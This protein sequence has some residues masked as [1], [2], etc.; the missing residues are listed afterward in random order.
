[1]PI[2][3]LGA[4][5]ILA[6]ISPAWAVEPGQ[7]VIEQR[8]I[9]LPTGA[10]ANLD[11]LSATL[12]QGLDSDSAKAWAIYRWL[13]ENIRYD[14][15]GLK[16]GDYGDLSPEGV[17][18]SRKAV[19]SGYS[20]LFK[21]LG[22]RAGL[23]VMVIKGYSRGGSYRAGEW[24]AQT[25]HAWNAVKV[26]GEWRLIDTTWGAG[27]VINGQWRKQFSDFYF[28]TAPDKFVL[29][30]LPSQTRWQLMESA[31]GKAQFV[32]F[33]YIKSPFFHYGLRLDSNHHLVIPSQGE[34]R[35]TLKGPAETKLIA[36]LMED[37]RSLAQDLVLV[38]RS[39]DG[40]QI[41]SQLPRAGDYTLRIYARNDRDTPVDRYTWV[42]DYLIHAEQG[43]G[44][45]SGFP[46]TYN[47]FT[48]RGVYLTEPVNGQLQGGRNYKFG[49]KVP[50]AV[51]VAVLNNS[52]WHQLEAG[53]DGLFQGQV[54]VTPGK[55]SIM[56][57]DDGGNSYEKLIAY[58]VR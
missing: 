15:E 18:R 46:V 12:T 20:G 29:T 28:L 31:I 57:N 10:D 14:M 42:L 7:S 3:L 21:A 6:F 51:K 22:E 13:T 24:S 44:E 35:V 17:L 52:Q 27:S 39:G 58:Q 11:S 53:P 2:L 49:L 40:F 26:D 5:C 4:L 38:Q 54:Q 47:A 25:D 56:A 9:N 32:D 30:H 23:E 48:Q 16:S 45:A 55:L 41:D 37:G 33:P 43:L 1:M 36:K 50:G 8:V 34:T 19:C